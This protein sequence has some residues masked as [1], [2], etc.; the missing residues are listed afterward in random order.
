MPDTLRVT[1]RVRHVLREVKIMNTKKRTKKLFVFMASL[2]LFV[3][4][5]SGCAAY[6]NPPAYSQGYIS[7]ATPNFAFSFGE[8]VN[9]YYAPAFGA[10]IYGYNGYYYRWLNGGWVYANVYAGPWYPVTAGIYL[11][12]ILAFGPPPPVIAYRPYFIW[13]RMHVGPW[14]RAYHPGW[15]ARH[16]MFLRRY[17]EWRLHVNR[18]YRNHPYQNWRM[19]RHFEHGG[20]GFRH[21]H[22]P[23]FRHE[24]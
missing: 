11:P 6:Y 1:P 3:L 5:L 13:W 22:G 15:W 20:P 8:G 12:G 19:R 23:F 18:F 4:I 24:R 16:R 7:V 17:R 21:G 14:Y 10:Y 9:A 2:G